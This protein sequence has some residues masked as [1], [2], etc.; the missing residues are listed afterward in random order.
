MKISVLFTT[1]GPYHLARAHALHALHGDR[2]QFIEIAGSQQTYAWQTERS[3]LPFR[4][5]TL[6]Q[7][8]YEDVPQ[9]ELTAQ[10]IAALAAFGPD[11]VA[12]PGYH[13][14]LWRGVARWTKQQGKRSL[15]LFDSTALDRPRPF[16][17]EWPKRLLVRQLFDGAFTAGSA[18]TA[19]LL[20]LG[21]P[22][23]HIWRGYD[24]VDNDYYAA[25]TPPSPRQPAHPYLI[26]ISRFVP[27]KNLLRLL[28][29]YAQYRALAADP[30]HLLL[31][32]D[33]ELRPEIEQT[34]SQ[35]GLESLVHLTG[36]LHPDEVRPLLQ[37]A[38]ALMLYSQSE[39]WGLVI[40]E[41]MAAGLP[42]IA[43]S[44]VGASY[45]LILQGE[46]GYVVQPDDPSTLSHALLRMHHLTPEEHERFR[47]RS[48][49]L[50][51]RYTLD[52]WARSLTNA[53]EGR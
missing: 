31:V 52:S 20:N 10:A 40:N 39:T 50:V 46:N 29:G 42:V 41:A 32:G 35:L 27:E 24:V 34:I 8:R 11:V 13:E 19:Y 33:G 53:A 16:W 22:F 30:W 45:D 51:E 49:K 3:G 48:R 4:L 6:T 25:P 12:T 26:N 18:S 17:K 9:R 21:M 37:R 28:E 47:L 36:F 5:Q 44:H 2:V 14:P 15:L 43:S 7:Q 23:S 38:Q 1:Y